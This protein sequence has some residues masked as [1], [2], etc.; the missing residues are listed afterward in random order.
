MSLHKTQTKTKTLFSQA[1]LSLFFFVSSLIKGVVGGFIYR[2][3]PVAGRCMLNVLLM[4]QIMSKIGFFRALTED[5]RERREGRWKGRGENLSAEHS[6]STDLSLCLAAH[7][8]LSQDS[9]IEEAT[10]I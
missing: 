4:E 8:T 6:T 3:A 7:H 1:L 10:V 5:E 9:C 2:Q